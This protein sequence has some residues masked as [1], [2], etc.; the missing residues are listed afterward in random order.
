MRQKIYETQIKHA[1]SRL[2]QI[3]PG[4]KYVRK[5]LT[6]LTKYW[7]SMTTHA[8]AT[9]LRRYLTQEGFEVLQAEDG[10]G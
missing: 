4:T 3:V 8:F 10:K 6:V 5:N 2:L 1:N 9:C 7:L